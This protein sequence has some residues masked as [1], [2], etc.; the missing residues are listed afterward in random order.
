MSSPALLICAPGHLM[1]Y[2]YGHGFKTD[3]SRCQLVMNFGRSIPGWIRYSIM[4]ERPSKGRNRPEINTRTRLSEVVPALAHPNA[5][6]ISGSA[7]AAVRGVLGAYRPIGS[8]ATTVKPPLIILEDL[9]VEEHGL[10]EAIFT[11]LDL[12]CTVVV[13]DQAAH[14]ALTASGLARRRDVDGMEYL[15]EPMGRMR[16]IFNW[17]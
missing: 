8:P 17:F 6:V 2:V 9:D 7:V 16:R 3:A 1:S 11:A 14:T 15:P 10:T 5:M 12:G 4:G 13:S